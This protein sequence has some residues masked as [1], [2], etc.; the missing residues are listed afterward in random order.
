MTADE[1]LGRWQS[2]AR[3]LRVARYERVKHRALQLHRYAR[4]VVL[5]FDAGDDAVVRIADREICDRAATH[6]YRAL[7]IKR[8]GCILQQIEKCLHK[9]ISIEAYLWQAGIIVALDFHA[10]ADL[11]GN[12]FDDVLDQFMRVHRLFVR[13]PAKAQQRI[14]KP[15]KTIGLADDDLRVFLEFVIDKL[16]LE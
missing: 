1:F 7:A 11:G 12:D 9:L 2:K 3:A 13:W 8:R 6:R 14:D 4:T 10:R 5:D 15:G 16:P